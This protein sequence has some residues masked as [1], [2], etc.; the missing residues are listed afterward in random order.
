MLKFKKWSGPNRTS[1]TARAAPVVYLPPTQ[2]MYVTGLAKGIL[3]THLVLQLRTGITSLKLVSK[4][5][6]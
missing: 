2:L 6:R 1:R 3:Y 4:L 5:L